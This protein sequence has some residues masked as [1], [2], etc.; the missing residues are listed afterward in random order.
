MRAKVTSDYFDSCNYTI[1]KKNNTNTPDIELVYKQKN[2]GRSRKFN[3]R[4]KL[5]EQTV[6][7][8]EIISDNLVKEYGNKDE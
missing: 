7:I 6:S 1:L 8:A 2:F 4:K 5:F 3:N